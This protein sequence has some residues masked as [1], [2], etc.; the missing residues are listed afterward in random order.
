MTKQRRIK[1]GARSRRQISVRGV[2]RTPTDLTKL[3]QALITLAMA[4]HAAQQEHEKRQRA[5]KGQS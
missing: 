4:E 2:R 1:K 3:S 5:A